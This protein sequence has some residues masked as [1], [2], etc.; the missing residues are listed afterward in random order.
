MRTLIAV[1]GLALV[2]AGCAGT[3]DYQ[4]AKAD[5]KVT[6]ITTDSV[7]GNRPSRVD[8]LAQRDAEMQLA[9]TQFRRQQLA[10]R[11]LPNNTVEQ[12]LRDCY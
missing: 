6:P 5:C 3:G 12:A 10:Q 2:L 4:Y 1:S 8:S 9:S 7:T 11:G